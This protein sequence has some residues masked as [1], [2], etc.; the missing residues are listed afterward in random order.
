MIDLIKKIRE[1]YNAFIMNSNNIDRLMTDKVDDYIIIE[2]QPL[3]IVVGEKI[4]YIGNFTFNTEHT[5]F[6]K[7][8]KVISLLCS[9]IINMEL[10]TERKKELLE[11]A[12]FH[13][14]ANGKWMLE[15]LWQDKWL[16]NKICKLIKQTVLK[17]QGYYLTKNKLRK[18]RSW[19]NC[20]YR[21][22][23]KN[24]TKEGLI[25]ICW[26]VYFY[27][28][29]SQKKSLKVLADKVNMNAL[30]ETYI[31]FWLQNLN[32][33]TGKFLNAQVKNIDYYFKDKESKEA[34]QQEEKNEKDEDQIS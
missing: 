19:T 27:N 6:H 22:F 26:L 10:T 33:L 1:K 30:V 29:D 5:F 13:L 8:A 7:W 4:I 14:L 28:F 34:S 20:S 17:Q 24:I 31:P 25:Q 2:E 15:F 21:Y 18:E 32:G 23:K 9:K 16:F 12:D 3:P 11:K